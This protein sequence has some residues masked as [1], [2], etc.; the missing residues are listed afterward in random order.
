VPHI[1]RAQAGSPQAT[2]IGTWCLAMHVGG[3]CLAHPH[4]PLSAIEHSGRCAR[5]ALVQGHPSARCPLAI[6][7]IIYMITY[8]KK[9]K[10]MT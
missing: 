4:A 9:K 8:N 3:R 10:L 1:E 6:V 7:V 2:A 5:V